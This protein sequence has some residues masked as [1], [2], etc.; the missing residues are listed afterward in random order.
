VL[1]P[2]RLG[3]GALTRHVR[4]VHRVPPFGRDPETWLD[5]ALNVL[6]RRRY[7]VLLP[8]QEQ[9]AILARDPSRVHELGVGLAVPPFAS[10]RRVQDKAAQHI[11]L[12]ELSLPHPRTWIVSTPDELQPGTDLPVY[13]KAPIG[14]ASNAVRLI[15]DRAQLRT[16][17]RELELDCDLIAQ[18]PLS[19]PLVMVQA[20]FDAGRLVCLHANLRERAGSSGGASVKRSINLPVLSD[21]LG[22]L[23]QQLRW[24]GALSL[25][26]VLTDAGPSYIDINPRLV[27]PG[28]AWRSGTDLVDALISVSLDLRPESSP[29]GRPDVRTHQLLLAIL[30]AAEAG[31]GRRGIASELTQCLAGRG[32]YTDSH[33]ELTPLRGDPVAAAPLAAATLATLISPR[34]WHW[35]TRGAVS[36]Y[37]LTPDA[38]RQIT[39]PQKRPVGKRR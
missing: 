9:T 23:G 27:E 38:W 33:E 21:H 5:A 28:N 31:R 12:Q 22:E 15:E 18:M 16:A 29:P 11:T 37:A 13:L 10:L 35:F 25:D 2:T 20:V 6:R 19:G 36:A 1:A 24:H 32:P 34:T 14:T 3:L 30:G 26:A 4:R 8:T 7:D 17:A 39:D